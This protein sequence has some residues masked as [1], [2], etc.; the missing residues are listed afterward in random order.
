M[1]PS[2]KLHLIC[3]CV[4]AC[5]GSLGIP[6]TGALEFKQKMV[7][8]EADRKVD[9]GNPFGGDANEDADNPFGDDVINSDLEDFEGAGADNPFGDEGVINSDLEEFEGG[10][11]ANNP[12]GD[13]NGAGGGNNPFSD[14]DDGEG[15]G[16]AAKSHSRGRGAEGGP[17]THG[18]VWGDEAYEDLTRQQLVAE[19]KRLQSQ[20]DFEMSLVCPDT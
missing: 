16:G 18:C 10:A 19:A 8:E 1:V 3:C 13:D 12:F 7:N 14:E 4:S 11:A 20:L 17:V 6:N 15:A 5:N 2:C 9:P